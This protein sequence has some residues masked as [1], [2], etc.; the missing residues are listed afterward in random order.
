MRTKLLIL[1]GSWGLLFLVTGAIL[2]HFQ[3]K[4]FC[5]ESGYR[6]LHK[7]DTF[8]YALGSP[9][10]VC[11]TVGVCNFCLGATIGL[12]VSLFQIGSRIR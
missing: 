3:V 4:G 5:Y 1:A 7:L 2:D 9:S 6:H 11:A 10:S 8:F 12:L